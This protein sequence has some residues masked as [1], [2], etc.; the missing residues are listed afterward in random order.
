NQLS[1]MVPVDRIY[2]EFGRYIKAG[3]TQYVLLNTSDLR[4]V[5]MTTKAVMDAAWAKAEF[6]DKAADAVAKV[7]DGYF[8]AIP[9]TP[10]GDDYGDQV[11]HTE[12]QQMLM[13]TMITPPWYNIVGQSAHWTPVRVLGFN[14]DPNYGRDIDRDYAATTSAREL[15]VCAD[16]QPHWDAVLAA[17]KAAEADVPAARRP[18]YE[19]Y[20]LNSITFNRNGNRMLWLV[21][22]AVRAVKAGDKAKAHQDVKDALAQVAEMKR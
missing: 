19:Y 3:A 2:S 21:S 13:T 10:S 22:D 7:W 1:E 14:F 11:Y 16:A 8:K 5:S 6:G 4:A 20:V 15:K 12:A 18:F 9:K 17:A